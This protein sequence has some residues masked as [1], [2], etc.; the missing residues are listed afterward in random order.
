MEGQKGASFGGYYI[1]RRED[2]GGPDEGCSSKSG[3][4]SS[5]SVCLYKL[6]ATEFTDN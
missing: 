4:K 5:V 3:K 2:D 6:E 1:N